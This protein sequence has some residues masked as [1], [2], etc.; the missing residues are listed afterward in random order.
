MS[1]Y[2]RLF[3][4]LF[5]PPILPTMMPR[6]VVLALLLVV[7]VLVVAAVRACDATSAAG[8]DFAARSGGA[9]SE[10]RCAAEEPGATLTTA[11]WKLVRGASGAQMPEPRRD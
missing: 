6:A 5:S 4:F 1:L 10:R 11:L 8:A 7:G 2:Q 3:E 9:C